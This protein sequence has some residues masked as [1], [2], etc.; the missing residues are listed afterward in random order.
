MREVSPEEGLSIL[1][2]ERGALSSL[3]I[4]AWCCW[5]SLRCCRTV[6]A[7]ALTRGEVP[8][9]VWEVEGLELPWQHCWAFLV[10]RRASLGQSGE[11]AVPLL[12]AAVLLSAF[13]LPASV[14]RL[15]VVGA[16]RSLIVVCHRGN[17]LF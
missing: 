10:S 13:V 7:A 5:C 3:H 16:L 6:P 4:S 12:L 15:H 2:A 8:P 14:L 17:C 9:H 1:G 11:E